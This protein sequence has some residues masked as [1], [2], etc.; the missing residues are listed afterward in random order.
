VFAIDAAAGKDVSA[1]VTRPMR[2]AIEG[3]PTHAEA[4][5][6]D[7]LRRERKYVAR[8]HQ[9]EAYLKFHGMTCQQEWTA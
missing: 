4:T 7:H 8:I 2:P 1:Y 3:A 6:S 5:I 9:L